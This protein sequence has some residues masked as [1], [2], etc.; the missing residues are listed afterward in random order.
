MAEFD[1]TRLEIPEQLEGPRVL[2]R[3]WH[4]SDA[5]ALYDAVAESMES[6]SKWLPWPGEYR[7]VADAPPAIRS[8]RAR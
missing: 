6:L 8:M 2:L 5:Q 4:D 7:S 1:P 3:P